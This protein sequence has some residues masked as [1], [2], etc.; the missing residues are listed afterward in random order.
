LAVIVMHSHVELTDWNYSE[1]TR[2][3]SPHNSDGSTYALS[4]E[5]AKVT[6]MSKVLAEQVGGGC[7]VWLV[8]FHSHYTDGGESAALLF[9]AL[10]VPLL[11]T[12]HSLRRDKLEYI[13]KNI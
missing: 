8:A 1:P 11:F 4:E 7:H 9:G 13:N 3:L 10:N 6:Q 12:G 5:I 2:M